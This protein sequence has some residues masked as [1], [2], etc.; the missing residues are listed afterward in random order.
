MHD[1]FQ[2]SRVG[3]W[4]LTRPWPFASKAG[5]QARSTTVAVARSEIAPH[6]LPPVFLNTTPTCSGGELGRGDIIEK[7]HRV[8]TASMLHGTVSSR[9][10]RSEIMRP[11]VTTPLS[12]GRA[13]ELRQ[14]RVPMHR[15]ELTWSN[16]TV[17]TFMSKQESGECCYERGRTRSRYGRRG[18][19]PSIANLE[20]PRDGEAGARGQAVSILGMEM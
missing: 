6:P 5:D 4:K 1:A 15:Y 17:D 13:H 7:D 20:L 18:C 2:N 8:M 12:L 19:I 9:R 16:Q 3:R 10:I 11:H 14:H